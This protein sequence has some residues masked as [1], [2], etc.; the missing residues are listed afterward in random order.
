MFWADREAF[1]GLVSLPILSLSS[2]S[3]GRVSSWCQRGCHF[4]KPPVLFSRMELA[5]RG[6][7]D[8]LVWD[9]HTRRA[10][11]G[12]AEETPRAAEVLREPR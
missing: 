6:G 10:I 12:L 11:R 5:L 2:P 9:A 7:P 8:S 3:A 4:S 1:A